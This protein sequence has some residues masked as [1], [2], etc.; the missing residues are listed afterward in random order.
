LLID[1]VARGKR[2]ME[3]LTRKVLTVFVEKADLLQQRNF[4]K[5]AME[6]NVGV[7]LNFTEDGVHAK[8]S[9]PDAEALEA[10]LLTVRMFIGDL[11]AISI[12]NVAKLAKSDAGLSAEWKDWFGH[13]R[14]ALNSHLDNPS[15]DILINGERLTNRDILSTFLHGDRGHTEFAKRDRLETWRAWKEVPLFTFLESQFVMV[16]VAVIAMVLRIAVVTRAELAGEP[17]P[18][19]PGNTPPA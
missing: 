6:E 10:A 3:D 7:S 11:D 18:P 8:S 13:Y 4:V 9:V 19:F 1:S 12:R 16:V 2:G 15:L 17:I 5:F 14:D